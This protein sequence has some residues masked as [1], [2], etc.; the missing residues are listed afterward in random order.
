MKNYFTLIAALFS[1]NAAYS[2]CSELFFSE[3]LEGSSNNKAIEIY[4]PTSSTVN[5]SG[6]KI[7][8][9]NNG[10]P[11]PTDSLA[12]QGTLAPGA[13]YVAGNPTAIAAITGVS[14]TLHTI[15]FFNGDD[16]LV[17]KNITTNTVL[18]I[19]GIVGVDPGTNWPVG[20]GATSEFT[21]VRKV[22]V[23]QGNTNWAVAATEYD[24]YPQNTTS[25][26]GN[27]TMNSCCSAVTAS[28]TA[29]ANVACF[30]DSTGTATIS[31]TGVGLTY[32]WT[33]Y[34]ANAA[35]VSN[36]AAGTYTV[37]VA[38]ACSNADT[39]TVSISQNPYLDTINVV[40]A[41]PLCNGDANG[42]ISISAAG[43]VSPYTYSWSTTATTSTIT[44]LTAGSYTYTITDAAGCT[45]T[46]FLN[47][48]DPPVLASTLA[49]TNVACFGG[50]TGSATISTTGGNSNCTYL[51][52]TNATTATISNLF[53]GV[54]SCVAT[55]IN[56]CSVTASVT[57][58]EP[59][60][61]QLSVTDPSNPTSCTVNDG[62]IDMSTLGGTPG[63]SYLWS[64]AATTEDI[65]NLGGGVYT[66]TVT[67]AGGCT[68]SVAVTLSAPNAPTATLA[69]TDTLLC[70]QPG[71]IT[72]NGGSPSGGTWS[73]P[74]VSGNQFDPMS[75]GAGIHTIVYTIFDTLSGCSGFATDTIEVVI[76][77]GTNELAFNQV[78]VYPNPNAGAFTVIT[79]TYS[80]L[81]IYDAQ[82]KLVAAQ[83]VQANVQ[84]QINIES[85][86]MYMITI[87][88]ADGSRTTQR[89]VV[90]K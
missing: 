12:P 41:F 10:S 51:W 63:Y 27:H 43:G 84:N 80:D 13:V 81:M 53:A 57:V 32:T 48:I 11:T 36:L 8:R 2:Q 37:I 19:I 5:L 44:G 7:Y 88:A 71:A 49:V 22:S 20:A 54:Y 26:I 18:D 9:Y 59:T 67:D 46:D 17:L 55:D 56:G 23:Q 78:N 50:A 65:S 42:S 82:G 85:S 34:G 30:G 76:C 90:T 24:V 40:A 31:A 14:D 89:V 35:T 69:L 29:S 6:Y 4:N 33:P 74:G 38:D 83:K 70:E 16:A 60:Q 21:L 86:G 1:V 25:F 45:R 72:L 68:S 64:N 52:N 75:A 58:T 28:V 73:G 79:P 62:Y 39:V 66:L 3:Y 47:L 15:T 77:I 61:L 87:V